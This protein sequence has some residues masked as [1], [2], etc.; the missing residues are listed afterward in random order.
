MYIPGMNNTRL[1]TKISDNLYLDSLTN[2]QVLVS[3]IQVETILEGGARVLG[4]LRNNPQ[5]VNNT[6][7]VT[8]VGVAVADNRGHSTGA[9]LGAGL[10]GAGIA[11]LA[12]YAMSDSEDSSS[13][14]SE[15]SSSSSSDDNSDDE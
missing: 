12:A 8:Q 4:T 10:V 5:A 3:G 9:L 15:D 13:S 14:Y 6:T 11:G 7:K 1:F 2:S